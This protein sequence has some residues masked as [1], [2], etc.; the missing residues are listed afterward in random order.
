V[1]VLGN[2]RSRKAI[3]RLR[4]FVTEC[5]RLR[6][7]ARSRGPAAVG[8]P[9]K[10]GRGHSKS[11]FNPENDQDGTGAGWPGDQRTI[12]RLH[13][14]VVNALQKRVGRGAVNG[15]RSDM[16]PDLYIL[17][18]SGQME[19]LFEIKAS[20][21]TQSWFTAIGQLLVYSAVERR[22]PQRVLVVPAPREDLNFVEA[23][24]S[25]GIKVVTFRETA[26]RISFS[27]L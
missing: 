20:S 5:E 25:L 8:A 21:D 18:R 24:K 10:R 11:V 9:S 23:L 13:G 15:T 14:R 6:I 1:F 26:G 2:V 16:R 19:T 17:N 12:R 4:D 27:G 3:E 22:R 7:I